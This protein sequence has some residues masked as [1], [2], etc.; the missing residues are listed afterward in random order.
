MA[1]LKCS[2]TTCAN[3]AAEKCCLPKIQ[4]DGPGACSCGQTCCSS[5]QDKKTCACNSVTGRHDVPDHNVTIACRAKN[6][7]YNEAGMCEA[8]QVHVG[9]CD[10]GKPC[11]ISETECCTFEER[12]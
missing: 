4:V 1:K 5:F 9:C 3:Y 11:V 2:V 8:G 10:T 7:K 6:C 12:R